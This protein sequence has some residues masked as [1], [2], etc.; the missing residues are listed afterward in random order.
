MNKILHYSTTKHADKISLTLTAKVMTSVQACGFH[1]YFTETECFR[2]PF[3]NYVT[4]YMNYLMK[5]QRRKGRRCWYF[6]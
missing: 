1:T 4:K 3:M 2:Y 5:K 6:L